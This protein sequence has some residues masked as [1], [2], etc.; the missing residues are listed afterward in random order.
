MAPV[1]PQLASLAD[2]LART[3]ERL[4]STEESSRLWPSGFGLLDATLSGG[5]RAGTLT[6]LAGPHG[7]GKTTFALQVARNVAV[8]G[9]SVAYFCYEHDPETLLER[10]VALEAG[11]L[12]DHEAPSLERIRQSFEGADH[13]A[14]TLADRLA[15]TTAGVPALMR[16]QS[17]AERL[18]L[19]RST[20][21]RTDLTVITDAVYEVWDATGEPPFVVVDYLQKVKAAEAP[22]NEDERVTLVVERLKDLAIDAGVPVLAVVAADKAGLEGGK[23]MRAQHMRGSTALA[24]EPDILLMINDKYDV[25]ARHHLVYDTSNADRFHEWIVLSVE[26]NRLGRDGIDIEF[27]KRFEQ[28]RFEPDGKRVAERLVDERV[29]TE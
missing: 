22:A 13:A 23:K 5:F 2:V 29:F 16:V 18:C 9:R 20:G 1:D 7:L 6:L 26:K 25:V 24:Y 19:H 4:L 11:E 17:Y 28:S 15:A 14:G 3:D 10:L 21:S 12:A 8:S 27:R